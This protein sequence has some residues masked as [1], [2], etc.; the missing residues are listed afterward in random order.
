ME[1]DVPHLRDMVGKL[2]VA[3]IPVLDSENMVFVQLLRLEAAG[4]WIESHRF[5]AEMLEHF[6]MP[7]SSTTLVLFVPFC[8]ISYIVSSMETVVLSEH[9][10]GLKE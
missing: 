7:V 10:L 8:A 3:R 4:L 5:N 6:D 9:A 1:A 2:I